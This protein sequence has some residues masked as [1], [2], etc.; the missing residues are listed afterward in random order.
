MKK[1]D[2]MERKDKE[3]P[4]QAIKFWIEKNPKL[5][6]LE[7]STIFIHFLAALDDEVHV[8]VQKMIIQSNSVITNS[9]GPDKSVRYNRGSL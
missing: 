9:S 3:V 2:S 8:Q 6:N 7:I 1:K 5:L 4:N